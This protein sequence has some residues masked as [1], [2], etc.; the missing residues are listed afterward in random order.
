M[1][2]ERLERVTT[3]CFVNLCARNF[4]NAKSLIGII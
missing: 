1:L 4:M 2:L 3:Y